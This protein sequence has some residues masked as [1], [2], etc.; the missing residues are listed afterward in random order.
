VALVNALQL[1]AAWAMP[2]LSRLITT[3]CQV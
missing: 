2:A 1:E 3:P